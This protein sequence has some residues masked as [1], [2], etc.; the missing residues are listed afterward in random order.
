[1]RQKLIEL[2]EARRRVLE[3]VRPL[4]GESVQ[5]GDADGRVLAET[6]VAAGDVPPFATSAMDGYATTA[7][8]AG[9]RLRI[10]GEARAGTPATASVEPGTA[11]AISTGAPLPDGAEAVI[12]VEATSREGDLVVLEEAAGTGQNVRLA[13]EDLAAGTEVLQPGTRLGAE[14]LAVAAASGRAEL[15]CAQVPRLAV[16]TTG[17]ELTAHGAQLGPG[18]IHDS[19][20]VMVGAL[21]AGAGGAVVS[22]ATAG[23][24][25]AITRSVLGDA[26]AAADV[27]VSTGGVSVG[28]HDHVKAAL[29][30]LGVEERFWR[31][32]LKPGK[33][34]W[35]GVRGD[36]L[37]FGLPGNPASA[38]VCFHLFVAPALRAL[39]SAPPLPRRVP[40]RLTA[41]AAGAR[42]RTHAVR[43]ALAHDAEGRLV[44]TPTGAQDSHRL[45]S[46]AGAD[47]LAFVPAD[48]DLDAGDR[49]DVEPLRAGWPGSGMLSGA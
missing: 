8:E 35:F 18:A 24:D 45:A 17:D 4:P 15:L 13:G 23:D 44:A 32:A 3:A 42:G 1:M 47:G 9:R 25:A 21:T 31:V 29:A 7:G 33:P 48:T 10:A 5:L 11:I 34:M 14:A 39:S 43:V 41:P 49:V 16:V 19:N 2:D 22:V 40:A 36:T 37:V 20:G 27:V 30:E 38:A 26:I 28:E 12:R 46:L 6:V